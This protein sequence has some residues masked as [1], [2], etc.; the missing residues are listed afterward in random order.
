M[1]FMSLL[2]LKSPSPS[3]LKTPPPPGPSYLFNHMK[4]FND[5]NHYVSLSNKW[6]I[7]AFMDRN[8][9]DGENIMKYSSTGNFYNW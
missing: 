5:Q 7:V 9:Q 4:M 1:M 3:H 6:D 8:T 2:C